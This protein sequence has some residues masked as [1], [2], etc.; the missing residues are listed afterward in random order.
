ML[1]PRAAVPIHWGTLFPIGFGYA[2][3]DRLTEPP[4]EFAR[5]AADLAPDVKVT[6]LEPGA[7]LEL[8]AATPGPAASSA[9]P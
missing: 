4:R 7:A 8:E 6:I 2:G 9:D 5:H 1:R 3:S